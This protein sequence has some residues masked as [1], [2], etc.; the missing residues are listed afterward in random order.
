MWGGENICMNLENVNRLIEIA[1]A[2]KAS[3]I[4]KELCLIQKHLQMDADLIFPLVG[5][6][7]S[8]K[9]TLI[10]ALTDS[11]K[12]ETATKPTTATIYK[13][14]FGCDH[15][16]AKVLNGDGTIQEYQDIADLKNEKLADAIVVD[17]FDTSRKVPSTTILVD[18][19]GL[20]SSDPRHKQALVDFLPQADAI[21][22]VTDVNQ[23]LTRSITEFVKTMELAKRPIFLVITKC[24]TKSVQDLEQARKYINDNIQL[25]IQQ[26]VCVSAVKNDLNELYDLFKKVQEEKT[27]IIKKVDEV[28]VKNAIKNLLERINELLKASSSDT[29]LEEALRE[30]E[31]DLKRLYRNIVNLVG[32]ISADIEEI[33]VKSVR[34]FEDIIPDKLEKLVTRNSPNFD[35]EAI[36]VINNTASL[37]LNEYKD[38]ILTV[39]RRKANEQQ[40]K[41][42]AVSLKSLENID[43]SSLSVSGL[44]YNINLNDLGHKYD[45]AIA[46]ATKIVVAAGA[47]YAGAA[48]LG[49][50]GGA[51]AATTAD[52]I[53]DA[54]DTA[55]DVMSM[56]SNDR[57]A[58]RIEKAVNFVGRTTDKMSSIDEYNQMAGQQVGASK[59]IVESMV[60]FVTDKTMGKPQRKR[61]IHNYMDETLKPSFKTEMKR[62]NNLII[63]SIDKILHQEA[64]DV[65]AQ[66]KDMLEQLRMEYQEK[67]NEF[68][69][70]ISQLRDYRNYLVTL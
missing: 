17:V 50:G 40:G 54:A 32:A 19:P 64:A 16:Y 70:R 27:E 10:N 55:T 62:I 65:M 35:V 21:L 14:H 46:M 60:G 34:Q 20:S 43:L 56:H 45:K 15:C 23:Q 11:K 3:D 53:L 6:F 1:K 9:T 31:S 49:A 29:D 58:S 67:K 61:A 18:T 51:I 44:N 47:V 24:D 39:F 22:L 13:L 26:V 57:T 38:D 42:E 63:S 12:L 69:Q 66:K 37:L 7:S 5:E 52:N 48:A 4:E 2:I 28:R 33:G 8:G 30:Q 59:G 41:E 36:S 25:S 68:E